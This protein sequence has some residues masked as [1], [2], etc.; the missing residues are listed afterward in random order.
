MGLFDMFAPK[1]KPMA[2]V[3]QMQQQKPAPSGTF[4][5]LTLLNSKMGTVVNGRVLDGVIRT[6]M[7]SETEN[8]KRCRIVSMEQQH[9][10]ISEVEA[11]ANGA[12]CSLV[13]NGIGMMDVQKN[14]VLKFA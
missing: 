14:E 11:D 7:R 4:R 10:P 6:G 1:K 5:A 8:G 9:K 13:L 3:P 12:F 2:S